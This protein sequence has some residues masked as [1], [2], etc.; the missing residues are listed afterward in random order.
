MIYQEERLV[1]ILNYLKENRSMSTSDICDLYHVSRDTAR[2]DIVRLVEQGAAIRTHGGIAL[3]N[4]HHDILAYRD[5]LQTYS[6]E[7][8]R[9]GQQATTLLQEKGCY[10]FNASTTISCLAKQLDK[11]VTVFTQSLD[12]AEL[13]SRNEHHSTVHLFGGRLN[14]S[15][16]FFFSLTSMKELEN[17]HFDSAFLGVAAITEDGLYYQDQEDAWITQLV[18]KQSACTVILADHKKIRAEGRFKSLNWGQFDVLITDQ[19]LPDQMNKIALENG[20]QVVIAK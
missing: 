6:D 4:L 7:K 12:V 5:R 19:P 15:N 20:T 3:L 1:T 8:M 14:T 16:R 18:A 9:I 11:N 17:I 13:L 10:F 2:R